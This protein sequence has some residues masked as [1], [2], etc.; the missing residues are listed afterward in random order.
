MK[1]Q[2]INVLGQLQTFTQYDKDGNPS[3]LRLYADKPL[4]IEAASKE[5]LPDDIKLAVKARYV[6][7]REIKLGAQKNNSV[8]GAFPNTLEG[9]DS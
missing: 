8:V 4:E 5:E 3:T 1:F 7:L 2:L 9:S 6:F